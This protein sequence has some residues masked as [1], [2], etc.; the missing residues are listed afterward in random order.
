MSTRLVTVDPDDR[1]SGVKEVFEK[2]NIHHIPVARDGKIQGLISK[3]DFLFFLRGFTKNED[4]KFVNEARLRA[5]KAGEIMTTGLA[6]MQPGE[7]ISK[8]LDI[9]RVNRFHAIPVVEAGNLV[10]IVT[11]FDI[12]RSIGH[13]SGS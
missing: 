13:E 11:T 3:T 6:T 10:G 1:L 7:P 8:A 2:Y 9:F 4:D 5:Y 12:I